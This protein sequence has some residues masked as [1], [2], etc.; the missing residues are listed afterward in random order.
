MHILGICHMSKNELV[1]W[2]LHEHAKRD[3]DRQGDYV[4]ESC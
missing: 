4:N 1:H 2:K 3:I